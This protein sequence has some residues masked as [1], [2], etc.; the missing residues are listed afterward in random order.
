MSATGND[1]VRELEEIEDERD[2]LAATLARIE[3]LNEELV[4]G[5]IVWR[6]S[7]GENPVRVWREHRRMTRDALAD[8]AKLPPSVV[9]RIEEGEGE[10]GFL[11]MAE[12]ARILDVEMEMLLPVPTEGRPRR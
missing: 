1:I 7:D 5:E 8:A 3:S 12:I 6:L 9:E 4:P 2:A 10:A 11:A